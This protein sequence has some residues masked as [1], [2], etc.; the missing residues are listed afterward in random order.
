MVVS[1][2][3]GAATEGVSD[4]VTSP[5]AIAQLEKSIGKSSLQKAKGFEFLLAIEIVGNAPRSWSVLA[6][7]I[8]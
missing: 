7:R 8:Q 3:G 6:H 5:T 4:L 1:G 2:S